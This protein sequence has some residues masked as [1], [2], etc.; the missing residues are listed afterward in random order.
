MMYVEYILIF[1]IIVY[2]INYLFILL[3]HVIDKFQYR[4]YGRIIIYIY[5]IVQYYLL[6]SMIVLSR[7][8]YWELSF[9]RYCE[10]VVFKTTTKDI[11]TYFI[12]I[13]VLL[14]ILT[15]AHKIIP[16][17]NKME[18]VDNIVLLFSIPL[19]I[20]LL[21]WPDLSTNTISSWIVEWM[22]SLVWQF[23]GGLLFQ[24]CS[25]VYGLWLFRYTYN[26]LIYMRKKLLES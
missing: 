21:I 22:F 5:R 3:G 4:K 11:A 8:V 14:Y 2:P 25:F 1:W 13:I 6:T 10:E 12:I 24:I 26:L 19:L 20:M 23:S 18:K 7:E 17:N 9:L 16:L 15:V